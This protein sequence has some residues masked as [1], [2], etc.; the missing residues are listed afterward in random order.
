M[1]EPQIS[2]VILNY[3]THNLTIETLENL[4]EI[5][6]SNLNIIVVD[7]CS[8]NNSYSVLKNYTNDNKFGFEIYLLK[9]KINK[10]YSYGN[11]I[12]IK[13]AEE[14]NS[15]YVVIMNNDIIIKDSNIFKKLINCFEL[16]SRLAVVGPGIKQKDD[17]LESPSYLKPIQPLKYIFKNIFYPFFYFANLFYKINLHEKQQE[18]KV[19]SVAGCF[20]IS[21]TNIFK[22]I[23]YLDENIF[24]YGEEVILGEK[25][26]KNGYFAY[27][28][29][30]TYIIH[31]HSSTIN[32]IYNNKKKLD[33]KFES[34]KYYLD[35]YRNDINIYVKKIM[36]Y[37]RL[38][39][40]VYLYLNIFAKNILKLIV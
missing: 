5:E 22:E 29:P 1:N 4:K 34:F 35:H 30:Q 8:P 20:F 16:D 12:G 24:L 31:N 11:N 7:N 23:N 40:R 39:K 2:I 38:L 6:Y 3:M 25:L 17:R 19:Y 37:S 21:K 18:K 36:L 33:M 26:L 9:T 15:K 27:Y 10:G 28:Y 32:S 13:K 14:L